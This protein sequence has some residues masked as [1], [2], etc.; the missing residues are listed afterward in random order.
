MLE[1]EK[2][3]YNRPKREWIVS[4]TERERIAEMAKKKIKII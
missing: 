4:K 3:I 1:H 2:E